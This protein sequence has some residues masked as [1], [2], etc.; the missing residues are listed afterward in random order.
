MNRLTRATSLSVTRGRAGS[1]TLPF[2]VS[3]HD[4]AG[5][6]AI[7]E[8]RKA[9]GLTQQQLATLAGC[10]MAYVRVIEAGYTPAQSDVL[11]RVFAVLN[12][13]RQDGHPGVAKTSGAG[14]GP[15]AV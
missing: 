11:P 8:A 4:T 10:S 13:R 3:A 1:G 2:M 14:G 5:P 6:G 7:R 9:A 12:E 15:D